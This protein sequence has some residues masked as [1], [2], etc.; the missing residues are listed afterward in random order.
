MSN[1]GKAEQ[2]VRPERAAL[3]EKWQQIQVRFSEANF[4]QSPAWQKMN[5]LVGHKVII[6]ANDD[7]WCLM[8]VKDAKRGRYLEVP[9][10]PLVDW[11]DE[12][13]VRR[14]F[15]RIRETARLEKCVFV[16]L[17]PQ[18]ERNAENEAR[19]ETLGAR[20]APMHLH[21]EHT[22]IID[23][24]ES[25]EQLLKNMRKQTRYEVR[26][27]EKLGIRVEW[28][29]SE[30]L[31]RE[32]HAVQAETAARQKFVPP[33]LKTLLAE[34]EA[35]G[36]YARI[37]VARTAE[38]EAVAYGLVLIDGIEAEYFEAASTELN[39]KIPGAYA[40]Q[41]QV[42]RDLKTLSVRR[43]NLWGIAPLKV[44]GGKGQHVVADSRHRYAGVTTFKTGF[45]GEVI[46]YV[47]AQDIIIKR[48]RYGVNWLI[49]TARKKKRHL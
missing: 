6:D 39:R 17:R 15:R 13:Q 16:R 5:E 27:A 40:L 45:G 10:G 37:Y 25:E 33:D 18:L 7:T 48:M 31:F 2:G 1:M 47:P 28:G 12:E 35:F 30:E 11:G 19:L 3:A 29:N 49:E 9:G 46:E 26:R 38:S 20:K 4:L 24:T 23:L 36:E 34:R 14:V 8:I 42:M 32:F 21:A 44:T 43:Y 22:V 41:W